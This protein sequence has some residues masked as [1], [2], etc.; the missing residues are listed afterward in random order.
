MITD[1]VNRLRHL[2]H[3]LPAALHRISAH[4]YTAK[5][6]P[7]KWSKKEILGHLI[8]SAAN[9]H[10]RF[11]RVQFEEMPAIWYDQDQWVVYSAHQHTPVEQLIGFWESYN[12]YLAFLLEQIPEER[13]GRLCRMKDGRTVTLGFLIDDYVAHLE[14]HLRQLTDY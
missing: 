11:V 5:P 7:G 12:R 2:C 14:H 10:Q 9:N 6:V 1:A 13:L 4:E 8:D 3:V